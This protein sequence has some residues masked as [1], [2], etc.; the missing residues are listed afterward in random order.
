MDLFLPSSLAS[1]RLFF[2]GIKGTGMTA[3][4]ELCVSSGA[5]VEG[6][7]VDEPFYT[8]EILSSLGVCIR[9]F[10]SEWIDSS[11]DCIV[12][13]AAYDKS[14][15]PQL[16][17]AA[18]LGLPLVSYPEALG[19]FS[20]GFFSCGISGVHGKT[21]TTAISGTL[22][23][24][25]GL[26]ALSLTGSAVP[27]WGG[28]ATIGPSYNV[29]SS[30]SIHFDKK[31][32]SFF[33][34]ETCE[35]RRH[36]MHFSPSCVLLTSVEPDHLDYFK[37]YKD[38]ESAFIDYT[39]KL[40][41]NGFFIYCAD[42]AGACSV[43]KHISGSRTDINLIS[44]G[45]IGDASFRISGTE[46]LAGM[47]R[48]SVNDRFSF[49]LKVPGEHMIENA[50]GALALISVLAV[51]A[52][53]S[54]SFDSFIEDY[55]DKLSAAFLAFSGTRRR[56]EVVGETGGILFIDD[57][58]HHPTAIR[59]TIAGYRSFYPGRRIVVDFMSHTYSRTK[60]LL[61]DF[62]AS[63][64]DADIVILHKIYASAREKSGDITGKD[65]YERVKERQDAVYYSHEV[66]DAMGLCRELLKPGDVFI[67]MGAGNN[68][69][70]GR[71]L[72]K[73]YSNL[74]DKNI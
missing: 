46:Q 27:L 30:P 73:Y 45:K 58:G 62:A 63:F 64:T 19:A 59:S 4:A 5:F 24:A 15:H 22:A 1:S 10:S 21:S 66:M 42:N 52:G 48:F 29:L 39:M 7:D 53:F 70:L 32:A 12:F 2:V 25:I 69:I 17:R 49:S 28:R 40:P 3:L 14:S 35:Y 65:L 74:E 8:D 23:N 56:S 61:D 41:E 47:Q 6:S 16:V 34:A 55:Y 11:W 57:Y 26:P 67:T 38:I 71:E 72:Y 43:A 44:Y 31:K 18:Q 60:A 13:S 51:K 54:E 37:D 36:F 9:D 33:I 50:V 68:W 20:Q